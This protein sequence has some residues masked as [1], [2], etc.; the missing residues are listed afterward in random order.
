LLSD[1]E[2]I[3][4]PLD[5][6]VGKHGIEIEFKKDTRTYRGTFL[7]SVAADQ[8]WDQVTTLQFLCRKA[9]YHGSFDSVRDNFVLIRRYQSIKFGL[10]Y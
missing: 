7:P 4:D 5:W 6:E 3:E 10:S 9:G 2:K 1:F 8:G